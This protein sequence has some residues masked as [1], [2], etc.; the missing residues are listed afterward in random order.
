RED[1]LRG[2]HVRLPIVN[3]IRPIIE[4]DYVVLPDPKSDDPKAQFATGFLKVTP[5]HDPN[6]Y[7]IGIRHKLP[8]INVLAPDGTISDQHGW[9][10]EDFEQGDAGFLLGQDRFE[11]RA[12]VVEWF[13]RN[14]LLEQVKPYRHS[15]GHSYRSHVP[16]EPYLSDQW[17]CK[18]TDPRLAGAALRAMATDQRSSDGGTGASPVQQKDDQ[19]GRGARA[20]EWEGKLTFYP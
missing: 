20:T 16:I 14:N 8:M 1:T 11:A 6:D 3:R 5:A 17:Y 19:H 15:V 12:A 13:R 4:D 10:R 9:P 7:D 18:V 2:K